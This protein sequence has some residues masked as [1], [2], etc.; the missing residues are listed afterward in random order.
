MPHKTYDRRIGRVLRPVDPMLIPRPLEQSEIHM[1]LM[2]T[3]LF[4]TPWW[5][6]TGPENISQEPNYIHIMSKLP[7]D[8]GNYPDL[9]IL[10]DDES[11]TMDN[12]KVIEEVDVLVMD[13]NVG[14]FSPT[15]KALQAWSHCQDQFHQ[16]I[17]MTPHCMDSVVDSDADSNFTFSISVVGCSACLCCLWWCNCTSAAM[18]GVT[19]GDPTRVATER[20]APPS[21]F[22]NF[23]TLGHYANQRWYRNLHDYPNQWQNRN[24]QN[25][26]AGSRCHSGWPCQQRR[27]HQLWPWY[28]VLWP[29]TFTA[30]L[31]HL[32]K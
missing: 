27:S 22:R 16:A 21:P 4:S 26:G 14:V 1:V 29:Y 5:A 28:T 12:E 15:N 30:C 9:A 25:N 6:L 20:D 23:L 7:D 31:L 19:R 2:A 10:S 3:T 13:K 32:T 18:H 17:S 11:I 24:W 8:Y